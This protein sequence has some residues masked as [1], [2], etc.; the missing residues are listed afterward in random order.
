MSR[1]GYDSFEHLFLH[2]DSRGCCCCCLYHSSKSGHWRI[3]RCVIV[4]GL[5]C[6]LLTTICPSRFMDFPVSFSSSQPKTDRS[7]LSLTSHLIAQTSRPVFLFEFLLRL[8]TTA[9]DSEG[10][11]RCSLKSSC[12]VQQNC[13][14]VLVLFNSFLRFAVPF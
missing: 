1:S 6:N 12:V 14:I 7:R 11:A 13:F 8:P 2:M 9:Q 10:D 5:R 3:H 4:L